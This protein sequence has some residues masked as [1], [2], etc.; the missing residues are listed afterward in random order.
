VTPVTIVAHVAHYPDSM[1]RL[2]AATRVLAVVTPCVFAAC[3][4]GSREPCYPERGTEAWAEAR[5]PASAPTADAPATLASLRLA[6]TTS[7]PRISGGV[8]GGRHPRVSLVGPLDAA[9][10]DTIAGGVMNLDGHVGLPTAAKTLR[11][12]VYRVRVRDMGWVDA[13]RDVSFGPGE[14]L[15]LE[16]QS[17]EAAACF[18]PF[19]KTS[20][21]HPDLPPNALLTV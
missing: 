1:L 19:I 15:E 5:Y 3:R 20:V 16:I 7:P 4:T 13:V 18:D 9:R 17:R 14:R 11:P 2:C 8:I 10:P 12:G 21:G 6:P